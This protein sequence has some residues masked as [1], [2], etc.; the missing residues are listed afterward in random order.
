MKICFVRHGETNYNRDNR[1]QG[2]VNDSNLTER[3]IKQ[4]EEIT[5]KLENYQYD[6]IITSPLVRTMETAK[7]INANKCKEII[8]DERLKERGYGD[9]EGKKSEDRVYDIEELWNYDMNYNL[10]QVEPIKTFFD[11]VHNFLNELISEK[12][13]EKVLI[14]S[15]GGVGIAMQVYFNGIPADKKLLELSIT[16]GEKVEFQSDDRQEKD[17]KGLE[18]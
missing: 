12:K 11:R 2:Q 9:F 16:N 4:A 3:G 18:L 1:L 6:I 14:V 15:H 5:K 8:V 17:S 13:Y 7:I 10:H